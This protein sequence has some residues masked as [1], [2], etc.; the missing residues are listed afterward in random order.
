[1]GVLFIECTIGPIEVVI[2]D[3]SARAEQRAQIS[4]LEGATAAVVV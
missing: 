4:W 3:K 1:M 2:V